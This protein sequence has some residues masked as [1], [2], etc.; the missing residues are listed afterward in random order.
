MKFAVDE[1]VDSRIV[2]FL[3]TTGH[4]VLYYAE[5]EQSTSDIEI[6]KKAEAEGRV[7]ITRDK[8][9]GELAFRDRMPFC[10]IL[11]LRL[12]K[13]PSRLRVATTITFLEN[14]QTHLPGNFIVMKPNAARIRPIEK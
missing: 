13:L 4:D 8:D 5:V 10:G 2:S 11:L 7:L 12:E 14:N 6:L 3:R 9:F 1:G